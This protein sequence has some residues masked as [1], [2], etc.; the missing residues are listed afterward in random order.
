MNSIPFK[1]KPLASVIAL[2]VA[3]GTDMTSAAD[4]S[5]AGAPSLMLSG[6]VNRAAVYMDNDEQTDVQYIDNSASGTRFRLNGDTTLDNGLQVGFIIENQYQDNPSSSQDVKSE[7]NNGNFKTRY[8]QVWI[9]GGLGKVGLGQAAGSADGTTEVDLSGTDQASYSNADTYAGITF[10]DDGEP[11]TEPAKIDDVINGYDHNSRYDNA[12]YDS[13]SLG[14]VTLSA[15]TG[16]D[17][18]DVAGRLSMSI[19]SS[20][21]AAALGWS[22]NNEGDNDFDTYG[23]SASL[24]LATGT[25]F[26]VSATKR[27][28]DDNAN[29]DDGEVWYVKLGQKFG[30]HSLSIDY[31]QG[32]DQQI[33]GDEATRYGL[34]YN[35]DFPANKVQFY[36]GVGGWELDRKDE[37]VDD[38]ITAIIGSRIKF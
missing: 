30:N 26:T 29:T 36:A 8:Q 23:G 5:K 12:R 33:D 32:Q 35:Y 19:G 9:K 14:P 7:D 38:I 20:K 10:R 17:R 24:L 27:D 31:G 13:P 15:S 18:H 34:A 11:L 16:N 2:V 21:L 6:Q 37:S 1:P 28:F 4:H 25:N 3:A 22:K